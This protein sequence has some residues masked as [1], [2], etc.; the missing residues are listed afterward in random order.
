MVKFD[1][2]AIRDEFIANIQE[3]FAKEYDLIKSEVEVAPRESQEATYPCCIVKL[4]EPTSNEKYAD[5]SSTYNMINFSLNCD[6][7]SNKLEDFTLDDSI[8][9]LSQILIEGILEKHKNFVVARNADVPFR[10][11]ILR[12]TVSFRCTYDNINK[13]IY[14]N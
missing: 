11:D 4:L 14:S 5:N 9:T 1:E 7:F 6:I 10:S 8:I 13:I 2:I 12:R 3:V